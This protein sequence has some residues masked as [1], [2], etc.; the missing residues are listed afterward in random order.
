M[1][2]RTSELYCLSV[3]MWAHCYNSLR[4]RSCLPT[5]EL[6]VSGRPQTLLRNIFAVIV[7]S[8]HRGSTSAMYVGNM[9]MVMSECYHCALIAQRRILNSWS[10]FAMPFESGPNAA[11]IGSGW[12]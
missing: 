4:V 6:I 9:E 3:T 10:R 11:S 5:D 2:R 1:W 12:G 7:R 8:A